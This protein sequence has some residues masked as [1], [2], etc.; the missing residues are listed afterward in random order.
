MENGEV[1]SAAVNL[2]T[3]SAVFKV[4]AESDKNALGKQAAELLTKQASYIS[5]HT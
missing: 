3:E 2:L 4:P 5:S 1:K